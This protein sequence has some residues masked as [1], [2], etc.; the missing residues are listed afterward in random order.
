MQIYR[1]LSTML[2]AVYSCM[3]SRQ[4]S[5]RRP[6]GNLT[7]FLDTRTY[8]IDQYSKE[9]PAFFR[10][11]TTYHT[12]I[13]NVTCRNNTYLL[14]ILLTFL[15]FLLKLYCTKQIHHH[16]CKNT[17]T[18]F[19]LIICINIVYVY[20]IICLVHLCMYEIDIN[21]F[22]KKIKKKKKKKRKEKVRWWRQKAP[23]HRLNCFSMMY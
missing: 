3:P 7:Q 4:V 2:P 14:T 17:H 10:R 19:N 23:V 11:I 12:I 5:S 13:Y 9:D 6:A 16:T 1:P 15:T 18:A 8:N 21:K 20:N 22:K